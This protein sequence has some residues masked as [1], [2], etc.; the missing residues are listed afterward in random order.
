[1]T[2]K[3]LPKDI[4]ITSAMVYNILCMFVYNI[5]IQTIQRKQIPIQ[6][7]IK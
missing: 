1:M 7:E 5:I 4:D 6:E 2:C 3:N